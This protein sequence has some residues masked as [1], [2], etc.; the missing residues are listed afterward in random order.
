MQ[1]RAVLLPA[2][3]VVGLLLLSGC[4]S[5]TERE[6]S[7]SGAVARFE[8]ALR[9]GAAERACALLAPGTLEELEDSAETACPTALSEAG[10]PAGG[11]VERVDVYGR[12]AMVVLRH[13]T[14][15]LSTFP[16]GWRITAAGCEPRTGGLPYTCEVKGE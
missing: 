15:F 9:S 6:S 12:E 3:A 10:L 13:D 2:A 7:A 1:Y 14:L 11:A 5:V 8:E 4:A 16:G